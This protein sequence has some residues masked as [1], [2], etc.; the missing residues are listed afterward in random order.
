MAVLVLLRAADHVTPAVASS[1]GKAAHMMFLIS[2]LGG[3]HQRLLLVLV[4]AAFALVVGRVDGF[5]VHGVPLA[6]VTQ[7]R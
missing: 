7:G 2:R 3:P 5:V 6:R 1:V 4:W